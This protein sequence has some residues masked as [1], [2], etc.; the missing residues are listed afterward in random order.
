MKNIVKNNVNVMCLELFREQQQSDIHLFY[1]PT[2]E[3][4]SKLSLYLS[5]A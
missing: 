4:V 5:S 3:F 1:L 2:I